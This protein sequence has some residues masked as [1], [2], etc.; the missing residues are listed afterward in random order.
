M[1]EK[2]RQR[3]PRV[4][5]EAV[6]KLL[7]EAVIEMVQTMPVED[8]TSRAIGEKIQMDPQVI[9]RNFGSVNN[10]LVEASKVMGTRFSPEVTPENFIETAGLLLPRFKLLIYLLGVG[11]PGDQLMLDDDR[12]TMESIKARPVFADVSERVTNAMAIISIFVLE[13]AL[14]FNSIHPF[15]SEEMMDA[16]QLFGAITQHVGELADEL[17]WS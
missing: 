4:S 16:V 7:V 2:P 8:I 15:T 17:G 12:A 6:S 10:L 13:G 3:A 5:G 9:F 1:S 11:V 14:A